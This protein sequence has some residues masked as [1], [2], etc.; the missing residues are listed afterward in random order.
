M[1]RC[2]E[3]DEWPGTGHATTP[4]FQP[5]HCERWLHLLGWHRSTEYG[6]SW[7]WKK[8]WPSHLRRLRDMAV[9]RVRRAVR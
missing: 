1:L 6:Q 8:H 2:R 9:F 3:V 5:L 7:G 4:E